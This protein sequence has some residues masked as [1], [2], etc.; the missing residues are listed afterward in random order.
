EAF[1]SMKPGA[2]LINTARGAVVDSDALY[3]ALASGRLGAAALDVTEPEPLPSDHRVLTLDRCIVI[4]HLGSATNATRDRMA[5]MA[6]EN[7]LAGV[8]GDRLPSC[9]NP[10][11]YAGR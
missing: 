5:R 4:P 6:A 2:V 3:D 7:L 9:V 1:R 11:V 8:H 10:Q